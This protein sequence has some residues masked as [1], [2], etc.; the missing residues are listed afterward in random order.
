[1]LETPVLTEAGIDFVKKT[2]NNS[3]EG[4]NR[5]LVKSKVKFVIFKHFDLTL[6]WKQAD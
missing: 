1:L 2:K 5:R 3:S 6:Q 4:Q